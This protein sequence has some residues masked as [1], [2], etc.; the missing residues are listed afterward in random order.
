MKKIIYT[1]SAA[2]FVCFMVSF[3]SCSTDSWDHGD[4]MLNR[5]EAYKVTYSYLSYSDGQFK[6]L[7]SRQEAKDLG[8]S[9]DVYNEMLTYLDEANGIVSK[10]IQKNPEIHFFNPSSMS[11]D[12]DNSFPLIK[13][14]SENWDYQGSG[15]MPNQSPVSC[16][17]TVPEG[18]T[19][20]RVCVYSNAIIGLGQVTMSSGYG[21]ETQGTYNILFWNN[22]AEFTLPVSSGMTI[23]LTVSVASDQGGTFS[24]QYGR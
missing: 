7:L 12:M 2:F 24:V 4:L 9:N 5:E 14:R 22:Y 8:V 1:L 23:D 17:L 21:Q 13:T 16:K 15:S 10:V 11:F 3:V 20:V 6:L 19:S 18:Y